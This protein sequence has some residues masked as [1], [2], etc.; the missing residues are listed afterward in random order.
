MWYHYRNAGVMELADV[1]DSKSVDGDIVRVRVPPPA[2]FLFFSIFA[3]VTL[4]GGV[5]YRFGVYF[6]CDASYY[7][8]AARNPHLTVFGHHLFNL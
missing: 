4:F 5:E 6:E 7:D 2:P 8:N 1:T 3:F